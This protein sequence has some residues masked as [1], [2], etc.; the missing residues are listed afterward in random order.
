MHIDTTI[1]DN[2][3]QGSPEWHD[4]RRGLMTASEMNLVL[5]PTLKLSDN[6]K[7]RTHV[8]ELAAQRITGYTEPSYVGDAMLRGHADEIK[9]RDLYSEK[10]EPLGEVGFVTRNFGAFTLG[11]SPDGVGLLGNFG[12]EAK[13]RIQKHQLKT[14]I[15]DE[16]PT[17]HKL[18]VQTG[19]LVT[20]WDY[21]EYISYSAGMPM[22]VIR[23]EPDPSYRDAIMA[24][25]LSF[26][27]K[28]QAAMK[29]YRARLETSRL[30][31]TEREEDEQ[32]I[33]L[34]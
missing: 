9:A 34:G 15:E 28:V 8:Y 30:F 4:A 16:V 17:E 1:H 24:A 18:Q 10:I 6:E 29:A 14:I 7:L 31:D 21:I 2:F 33:Y 25:A 22:C 13:S 5:T 23:E 27:V 3:E 11:Y 20:G 26:E 32:E 12:M 19:L